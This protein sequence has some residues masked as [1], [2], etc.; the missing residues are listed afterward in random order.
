MASDDHP[1]QIE[2]R[3]TNVSLPTDPEAGNL[4]VDLVDA[5]RQV[6]NETFDEYDGAESCSD[7]EVASWIHRE[8]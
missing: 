1:D 2:I 5:I 3:V 4:Q 6:V 7:S 8:I